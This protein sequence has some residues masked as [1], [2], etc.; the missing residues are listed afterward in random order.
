MNAVFRFETKFCCTL[1]HIDA[2]YSWLYRS[3]HF[4]KK[5]YPDRYVNNIYFD[6]FNLSDASDNLIGLGRREKLRLRWYGAEDAR[7]PM[8]LER[9]IKRDLLGTKHV[10]EVAEMQLGGMSREQLADVLASVQCDSP[11]ADLRLRN[12]VIRNRYLRE[13]FIDVAERVRITID[14]EQA[15]FSIDV[16]H[17][18]LRGNRIDYPVYV[19]EVK[20]DKEDV[21]R[22]KELM[23][24]FPLRPVRHSKYLAGLARVIE[25]P[26]Y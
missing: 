15:F 1:H 3:G 8:R 21:P 17:D 7:V 10:L 2:V 4:I 5:Q 6:W 22:L 18:V 13:Y 19:I 14:R 11:R 12:P 16:R 24:G 9:K 20:Y 23:D 26:Y 25:Q